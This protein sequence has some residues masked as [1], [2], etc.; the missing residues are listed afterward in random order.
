MLTA[1]RK[2]GF[3]KYLEDRSGLLNTCALYENAG[4]IRLQN[5]NFLHLF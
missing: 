4:L 2:L 5:V 3:L 1:V